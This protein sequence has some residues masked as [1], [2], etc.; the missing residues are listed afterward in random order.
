MKELRS[1]KFEAYSKYMEKHKH[2]IEFK[3]K[4]NQ[5]NRES[6]R[7]CKNENKLHQDTVL[8]LYINYT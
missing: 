3:S 6:Y 2:D 1:S 5:S 7:K 8:Y 4:R